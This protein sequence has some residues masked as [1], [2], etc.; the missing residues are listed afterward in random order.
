MEAL[1]EYDETQYGPDWLYEEWLNTNLSTGDD[2]LNLLNEEGAALHP[3]ISTA[4]SHELTAPTQPIEQHN[5]DDPLS[6]DGPGML[7]GVSP[8]QNVSLL[9]CPKPMV[10]VDYFAQ[11][12]YMLFETGAG[13]SS[14]SQ[15][16]LDVRSSSHFHA[17]SFQKMRLSTL[18]T[19][20]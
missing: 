7:C 4:K 18:L 17:H 8:G 20:E 12:E 2:E 5:L 6:F 16:R 3:F 11:E 9:H 14:Y 15:H 19:F 13:P 10:G 1:I